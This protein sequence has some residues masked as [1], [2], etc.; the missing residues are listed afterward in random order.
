MYARERGV[1]DRVAPDPARA[2]V[3]RE[4]VGGVVGGIAAHDR[5]VG[6]RAIRCGRHRDPDRVEH[7]RHL[8]GDGAAVGVVRRADGQRGRYG[9]RGHGRAC[10]SGVVRERGRDGVGRGVGQLPCRGAG[11]HRNGLRPPDPVRDGLHQRVAVDRLRDRLAQRGFTDAQLHR[12][13]VAVVGMDRRRAADRLDA[14]V[15]ARR[16]PGRDVDG[17]ARERGF[18][19]ARI[20]IGAE[21]DL[22]EGRPAG[23]VD[24][25]HAHF[26]VTAFDD[27]P[28]AAAGCL[29]VARRGR[30]REDVE[31]EH[32]QR[33]GARLLLVTCT[34]LGSSAM[35]LR[36]STRPAAY[37]QCPSRARSNDDTTSVAVTGWPSVQV[38][39]RSVYTN[40]RPSGVAVHA[41]ARPGTTSS[42]LGANVVS[43]GYWSCQTSRATALVAVAGSSEPMGPITPIVRR[44]GP[45]AAIGATAATRQQEQRGDEARADRDRARATHA[46]TAG[47]GGRGESGAPRSCPGS[48]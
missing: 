15:V 41:S 21:D 24:H 39:G 7:P 8:A 46:A 9:T 44:T 17:A 30:G 47:A 3:L 25:S 10:G 43:V 36:P 2:R 28:E 1:V 18:E 31:G 14:C 4:H 35:A 29:G 40:P 48:R 6:R 22:V 13:L 20:G 11:Y 19:R 45:A 27:P 26:A 38:A 32:R 16:E 12:P 5:E 37:G 34:V 42:G 33:A 23:L